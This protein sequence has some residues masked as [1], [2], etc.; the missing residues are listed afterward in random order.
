LI[1]QRFVRREAF[2]GRGKG[3]VKSLHG[4]VLRR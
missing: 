1:Q 4:V 2:G 3:K